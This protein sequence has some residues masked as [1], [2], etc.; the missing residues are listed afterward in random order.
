MTLPILKV[1]MDDGAYPITTAHDWD[2][3]YDIRTPK[4]FYLP[5]NGSAIVNT[6]VHIEIPCGYYAKIE[7]KSGLMVNHGITAPG[8]VIDSGYTGAI[9]VRLENRSDSGYEFLAGDKIAQIIIMAH[10]K[11]HLER[12]NEIGGSER[13]DNGF[14]S[15]GR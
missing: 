1:K 2:A 14:G 15:S 11:P 9:V 8:G 7:S 12:V 13:G 5:R 3:G 6:G 10:E 4:A